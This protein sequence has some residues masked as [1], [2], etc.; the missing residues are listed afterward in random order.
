MELWGTIQPTAHTHID[1]AQQQV[2][3]VARVADFG[4]PVVGVV[5]DAAFFVYGDLVAL[6]DPLDGAFAVDDVVVG[7][8][9]DVA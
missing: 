9:G 6:H 3:N 1:D 2:E 8:G 7:F 5:G 4:G